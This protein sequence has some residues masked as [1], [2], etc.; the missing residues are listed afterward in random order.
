MPTMGFYGDNQMMGI[1]L[2]EM[3]V[4]EVKPIPLT[5]VKRTYIFMLNI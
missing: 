2:K 3:G 1:L 4:I 5:K